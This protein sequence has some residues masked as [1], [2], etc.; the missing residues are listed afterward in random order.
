MNR[1]FP[2]FNPAD[3]YYLIGGT[4]SQKSSATAAW[5]VDATRAWSTRRDAYVPYADSDYTAWRLSFGHM[6]DGVEPAT[7]VDGEAD[8]AA[9]LVAAGITTSLTP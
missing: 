5:A 1:D 8:V 4:G 2:A 7:R 9:A 6:P 3:W